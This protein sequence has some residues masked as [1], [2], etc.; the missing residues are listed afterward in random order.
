ME[1]ASSTETVRCS[2]MGNGMKP[3]SGFP[4]ANL[5]GS[6]LCSRSLNGE[7]AL[8]PSLLP[9]PILCPVH[10][11]APSPACELFSSA[12]REMEAASAQKGSADIPDRVLR[13]ILSCPG[14]GIPVGL[15]H[16]GGQR[17]MAGATLTP[18]LKSGNR[19][20]SLEAFPEHWLRSPV[21]GF[22]H[23]R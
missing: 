7:R 19:V 5:L 21:L 18:V 2:S 10:R 17:R 3:S 14:T 6:S 11:A 22:E 16:H 23:Q 20:T 1:A 15:G 12:L 9:R 8:E 4:G 13:G